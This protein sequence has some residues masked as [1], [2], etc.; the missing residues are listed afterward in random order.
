[1][2]QIHSL[3]NLHA[4][5]AGRNDVIEV[6]GKICLSSKDALA[7]VERA[8]SR[9]E[10][11]GFKV[12]SWSAGTEFPALIGCNWNP[13]RVLVRKTGGRPEEA[14]Q[15]VITAL[16]GS[17]LDLGPIDRWVASVGQTAS[18]A[19]V[20]ANAWVNE[21]QRELKDPLADL[22]AALKNVL[23]TAGVL[24]GVGAAIFFLPHIKAVTG[25]LVA[26]RNGR[27]VLR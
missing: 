19:V 21:K 25:P 11:R 2:L 12:V 27:Q 22:M 26:A 18:D 9:I 23:I 4:G 8:L 3:G 17:D 20:D 13:M 6:R 16:K 24:A 5:K 1:M 15:V 7:K 10:A 14:R